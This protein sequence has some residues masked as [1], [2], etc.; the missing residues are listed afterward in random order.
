MVTDVAV[1]DDVV[2]D[3]PLIP[4]CTHVEYDN[5]H[6]KSL[7]SS[8]TTVTSTVTASSLGKCREVY[9]T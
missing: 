5:I 7:Q 4:V 6:V 2:I 8:P 3:A 1:S 9:I